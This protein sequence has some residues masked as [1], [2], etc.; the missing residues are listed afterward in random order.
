M[1]WQKGKRDWKAQARAGNGMSRKGKERYGMT[2]QE[3]GQIQRGTGQWQGQDRS[4]NRDRGRTGQGRAGQGTARHGTAQHGTARQ[5]RAE[6]GRA[7]QG[8][9]AGQGRKAWGNAKVNA[10][11]NAELSSLQDKKA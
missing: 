4:R 8:Y 1:A 5:G 11:G 10:L 7:G 9:G 6:Q 3:Q 2:K